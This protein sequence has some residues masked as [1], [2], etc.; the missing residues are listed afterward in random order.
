MNK[1]NKTLDSL[2]IIGKLIIIPGV[3]IAFVIYI[4]VLIV[5]AILAI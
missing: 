3:I 2:G 4:I 1:K 5:Q